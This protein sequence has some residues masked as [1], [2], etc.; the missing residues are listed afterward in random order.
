MRRSLL[1]FIECPACRAELTLV[2][3]ETSSE[4]KPGHD[5]PDNEVIKSGVLKCSNAHEYQVRDYIPRFVTDD[6]YVDSFSHEWKMHPATLYDKGT[7]DPQATYPDFIPAEE[8]DNSFEVLWRRIPMIADWNV[9]NPNE[10]YDSFVMKTGIKPQNLKGQ[11]VVEIG[12]GSGRFLD[13]VF[14]GGA[15]TFGLDYSFGVDQAYAKLGENVYLVQGDMYNSPFKSDIFDLVYTIGVLHHTPSVKAAVAQLP[16]IAKKDGM[17]SI[18]IYGRN[19]AKNLTMVW[20]PLLKRLPKSALYRICRWAAHLYPIYRIPFV[21]V[22]FRVLFP[23]CMH[24]DFNFRVHGNFDCYSPMYNY[25]TSYRELIGFMKEAGI[26]RI[27]LGPFP[28]SARG[29]KEA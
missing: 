3:A 4:G 14:R 23:I 9:D 24:P 18:W 8:L 29:I 17:I 22:P 27:E 19:R 21:S 13:I 25:K 2:A 1:R 10:S 6:G 7:P 28:T 15:V 5:H 11:R 12:C 20:W 16:R 26:T